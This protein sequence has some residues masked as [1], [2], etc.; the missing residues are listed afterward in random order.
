MRL[1]TRVREVLASAHVDGE[2]LILPE[3]LDRT[4]Y[5]H[6]S[7]ALENAGGKWS[8]KA[9]A[10]VFAGGAAAAIAPLLETGSVPDA[11]VDHGAFYTPPALA[12]EVIARAGI[13]PGAEVLEPSAGDGAL[14]LPAAAAGGQVTCIEIR[15][16]ACAALRARGVMV[17]QAD[18][19][20]QR[21]EGLGFFDVVVMNPPFSR[22]QDVAHVRHALNF[23]RPGGRLVAVVSAGM[24]S[25][26]D[27]ATVELRDELFTQGASF[28]RLPAGSFRS[29]GTEVQAALVTVDLCRLPVFP[30]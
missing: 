27:R 30:R 16:E 9:G 29:A 8:R 18:F 23:V 28:E 17:Q 3:R 15:P 20:Q 2:R 21:R 5:S 22:R 12:A 4:V 14:A 24:L 7:R 26:E 6:V 11:K 19:L 25:R 13:R 1:A 10:H